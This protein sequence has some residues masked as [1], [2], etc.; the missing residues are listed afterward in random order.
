MSHCY[1]Y[2]RVSTVKQGERGVSLQEQRAAIEAYAQRNHIDI[3]EWFEERITA[4]KKGRPLFAEMLRRLR[5]RCAEGAV[6]HTIDRSA[7]NLRDWTDLSE[8]IDEGIAV[9]FVN[10]SLD[11]FSRGGR[12]SADIQAVVAADYIRNLREEAKKGIKGRLKQGILPLPA[13]VG[14]LDRGAGQPKDIDPV[15]G[16]LV[17]RAFELYASGSYTLDTLSEELFRLGLR[18][19]K[20]HRLCR[21]GLSRILNNP[22]YAGLIRIRR[23]G[24]TYRGAHQPLI[25]MH[26]FR[27]VEDRLAGKARSKAWRHSF[28]FRGLFKCLLCQRPLTGELQKGHHYYRCHGTGCATRGFREEVLESA[29]LASWPPIAMTE[30]DC[31]LLTERLA[32]IESSITTDDQAHRDQLEAQLRAL[33]ARQ[34]KLVDAVIDGLIDKPMF[35]ERKAALLEEERSLEDELR[36]DP[37]TSNLTDTLR[38]VFE[39][40]IMAQQSYRIANPEFKRELVIKLCSNLTV[41]GKHVFVEPH[42]A[43]RCLST[44]HNFEHGAPRYPYVRTAWRLYRWG[45]RWLKREAEKK[46]A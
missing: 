36:A 44:R 38:P 2:I 11:L 18:N 22:F 28:L 46:A 31:L 12:L 10:E 16:P 29:I 13:P 27:H 34:Q 32:Q 26:L 15:K 41:A 30:Q 3:V 6:M 5:A 33:K 39:L 8:L 40:A 24:E 23:S 19:T 9:H 37:S 45:Q 43:V 35:E 14:Y 7:R 4:A 17:I 25:P 20:G 21:V 1:G 42:F